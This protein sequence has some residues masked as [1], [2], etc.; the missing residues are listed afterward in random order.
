MIQL[1]LFGD[2]TDKH[3]DERDVLLLLADKF[4]FPLQSVVVS[5]ERLYSLLDLA[6]GVAQTNNPSQFVQQHI[7]RLTTLNVTFRVVQLPYAAP[8]GK[9]RLS[10]FCDLETA[11][12]F[13]Q[14]MRANT[15]IRNLVIDY[16][17]KAGVLI[18]EMRRDPGKALDAGIE[19]YAAQGKPAA[20][21][22]ARTLGKLGNTDFRA[23]LQATVEE[24]HT[25]DPKEVEQWF[26]VAQNHI[27]RGLWQRDAVQLR[28]ELG[29]NEHQTPREHMS[30]MALE[31][32][33][34]VEKIAT[35]HLRRAGRVTSFEAMAL[36]QRVSADYGVKARELGNSMGIDL[37]T[38]RPLLRGGL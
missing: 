38:G 20:W 18:D 13:I 30:E 37:A 1:S 8:D 5:G 2:F 14:H 29:L 3:N 36:L 35:A 15:G 22:E 11:L 7:S 12:R 27:Y 32:Q 9:Q 31:F 25:Y 6:R 33:R 21:V 19:G 17:A 26:A 24:L 10:L 28:A 16:L 34:M 23:A 4:G